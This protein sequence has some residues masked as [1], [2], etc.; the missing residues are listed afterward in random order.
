M[1]PGPDPELSNFEQL[2]RDNHR[3]V[4]QVAYAV[5]VNAA[6]AE[7]VTQD[8]FLRAYQKFS[9]LRDPH[10]FRAWVARMSWRLALNRRRTDLRAMQ[11]DTMWFGGQPAPADPEV[12]AAT[13]ELK[14]QIQKSITRLPEKLRSVL[15]LCAIK[16]LDARTV[17]E[18]LKIPEA[19]VRTRLYLARRQL[20][21][22]LMP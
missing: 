1:M 14:L 20:L 22:A 10:K 13:G 6:D 4:Y 9:S 7:E 11:R 8:A 16:E 12:E 15:L 5:L 18:I 2:L 17:G 3:T 19:T 21:K